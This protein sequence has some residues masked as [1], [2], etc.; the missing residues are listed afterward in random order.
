MV[1]GARGPRFNSRLELFEL[2]IWLDPASSH[3]LVSIRRNCEWIIDCSESVDADSI[4]NLALPGTVAIL[5][6]GTHS[7]RC[8]LRRPFMAIRSSN[9]TA[10]GHVLIRFHFDYLFYFRIHVDSSP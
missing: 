5:A 6:Q 3:M 4:F 10:P 2:D 7:G 1:L 9:L 8:A